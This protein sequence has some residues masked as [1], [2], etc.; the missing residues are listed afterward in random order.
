M[1]R[2][3]FVVL[4]GFTLLA[5][6]ISTAQDGAWTC[7][8]GPNDVLNAAQAALKDKDRDLAWTLATQAEVICVSNDERSMKAAVLRR[9]ALR[10][11]DLLARWGGSKVDIGDY[12]LY[13]VCAGEGSPTLILE[14]GY[15]SLIGSWGEVFPALSTLTRTCMYDRLGHDLSDSVPSGVVRT[16]Q[17][18]VDDLLSLLETAEIEPPYI[19]MGQSVGSL[20]TLLMADQHPELV[21]GVILISALHPQLFERWLAADPDHD[22]PVAGEA[23]FQD[24]IDLRV[25]SE[26]AASIEN[27]GDRPL[28]V[29]AI[30]ISNDAVWLEANEELAGFSSNSRYIVDEDTHFIQRVIEAVLWVLEELHSAEAD[31]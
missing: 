10:I 4:L 11:P 5:G 18:Q 14:N 24:K 15:T 1:C 19:L 13:L 29:L 20:N 23:S 28:A 26:Q 25:S 21:E 27:L 7:D 2:I 8:D 30:G 22:V 6:G 12:S 16:A 17:E 31:D 9:L 3:A